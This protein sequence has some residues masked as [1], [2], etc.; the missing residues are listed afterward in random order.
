MRWA[1]GA[2][3]VA[4]VALATLSQAGVASAG[5]A[6]QDSA[7]VQRFAD[8]SAVSGAWSALVR[9]DT[10]ATF[11]LHTRELVAGHTI[12]VW[13]VIFNQPENCSHGMLGLR[14]GEGDLFEPSVRASVVYGAGHVIGGS[15]V[16][17]YGGW[18]GV[19]ETDGALF[20]PGLLEPLTADIHLVVHDHG[21][22]SA[23]QIAEGVH[24][25]GPCNPCVDVQFSA[26]E[27][28]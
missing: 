10:G 19:A 28:I 2:A 14:C 4:S 27:V 8:G 16:A 13:W 11:S 1:R 7:A 5:T 21:V 17:G 23:E 26:H 3:V 20:G 12:T 24:N 22:L 15:G 25:F 9:N 18:I 6:Q